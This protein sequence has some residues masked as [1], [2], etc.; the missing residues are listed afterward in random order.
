MEFARR[1]LIEPCDRPGAALCRGR[2]SY[3]FDN[4]ISTCHKGLEAES[5]RPWMPCFKVDQSRDEVNAVNGERFY[6]KKV[7]RTYDRGGA[8]KKPDHLS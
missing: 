4:S 7:R 5:D 1:L 3:V 8:K 2:I 6:G